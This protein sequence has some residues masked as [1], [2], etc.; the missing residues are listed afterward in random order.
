MNR[1][2]HVWRSQIVRQS[3]IDYF[4]NQQKHQFVP[5]SSV[6]PKK[7][8]GTYFTNAGM[9]QFRPLFLGAVPPG[10]VMADYKRVVNSQKCIRVG[11]KHNDLD[12]VGHDLSHH[13][14]FEMLGNW[15][16]GDYFKKEACNMAYKLLTEVYRLPPHRL[17]FTYFSGEKS[18]NL[19]PDEECRTIWLELGI[20]NN[21]IL[22]FGMKDNFWDMGET[23]PCGPCTEIHYDHIGKGGGASLVNTG[24]AEVVE[25]WNLVFMQYNRES[26]QCLR[27]LTN[28]HVDTGMGLERMCA[29]LHGT[30]SN[31]RTD[32]FTP[33]FDTIHKISKV[34]VYGDKV[35]KDDTTGFD[36]AYRILA[37]HTRMITA[38]IADG[39]L[40]DRVGLGS[41]VRHVMHR[42]IQQSIDVFHCDKT[43][44]L[45]LVD[46]VSNSL[47]E[48]YP[49]IAKNNQKIKD[50]ISL[51]EDNYKRNIEKGTKAFN[52][53][54]NREGDI[55]KLTGNMMYELHDGRYGYHVPIDLIL[56]LAAERNLQVDEVEFES[57]LQSKKDG[58]GHTPDL[59]ADKQ[60]LN[61]DVLE[62]LRCDG[63]T[64]DD[65]YKYRYTSKDKEYEF[66]NVQG[67]TIK[68]MI[69]NRVLTKRLEE[70]T[71]G[72]VIVD[73]TNFYAEN[74]GQ[75]SDN[76]QI[77][78]KTGQGHITDVQMYKGHILHNVKVTQ[79]H[80]L[81][82][83]DAQLLL[84]QDARKNHMMNHTATH[85]LNSAIKKILVDAQ[86]NGSDIQADKLSFDLT[87]VGTLSLENIGK[88]ED[89]V[90]HCIQDSCTVD[91]QV[92]SLAQAMNIP[93]VVSLQNEVY[94]DEVS[95][96]KIGDD[97]STELCCG[98]H[99]TNTRDIVDFC[100]TKLSGVSQGKKRVTCV[101]GDRATQ[102]AKNKTLLEEK[103]KQLEN[104]I[105]SLHRSQTWTQDVKDIYK[106]LRLELLPKVTRDV[107][108][109]EVDQL[110]SVIRTELNKQ[111]AKHITQLVESE[112]S[113]EFDKNIKIITT[114]PTNDIKLV[115]KS[116]KDVEIS[117][118]IILMSV[119]HISPSLILICL[120]YKSKDFHSKLKK[121][122]IPGKISQVSSTGDRDIYSIINKTLPSSDNLQQIQNTLT[123]LI[124]NNR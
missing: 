103:Y 115:V 109:V 67:I 36:T 41:K 89:T 101:T 39:L 119:Q 37:D 99:V 77:I 10:S 28:Q 82:D 46:Q 57:I 112:L 49:E 31:Y 3:F 62:K 84:N 106:M 9:N 47:G 70:G 16:F 80:L 59:A 113:T 74:G 98:T 110:Q 55:N 52:K 117:K 71:T 86:Q 120:P 45:A 122:A 8:E 1:L 95:V 104:N 87:S 50:V 48:T 15:S 79:G 33:L 56:D 27:K 90:K 73:K 32:L 116:I 51:T 23:G 91:R 4:K 60:T 38:T 78:T 93:G 2:K 7:G 30:K 22:P 108:Q 72:F 114:L 64:T 58:S 35:G 61:A 29:V 19:L 63:I 69:C 25:I 53:M 40:P 97:V 14:F 124:M 44:L 102:A 107:Y 13:T 100:I 20:P 12:D 54:M 66:E 75:S 85:L 88:I 111:M 24:S 68:G 94:P 6:I 17:Y 43:L 26:E 18:L 123:N 21:Q 42:A 76:G 121:S 105:K 65:S 96:I 92:M 83:D 34:P 81:V 118:P 11:G 5:S